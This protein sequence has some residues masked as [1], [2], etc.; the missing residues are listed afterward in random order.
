MLGTA[1]KQPADQLDYDLNF[2]RWLSPDDTITTASA[3]L[4][5]DDPLLTVRST[6]IAGAVV[7]VWLAG[8][9]DGKTS[10]VTVTIGTAGGRIKETE[11]KLRVKDI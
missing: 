3:A 7:K 11:F 10:V 8:G 2:E 5:D 4:S 1:T 9:T 6:Q